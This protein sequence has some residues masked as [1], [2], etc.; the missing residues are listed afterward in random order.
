MCSWKKTC[1]AVV[2]IVDQRRCYIT[3]E[4]LIRRT[5]DAAAA[6]GDRDRAFVDLQFAG[7]PPIRGSRQEGLRDDVS[8]ARKLEP[9]DDRIQPPGRIAQEALSLPTGKSH[10]PVEA[11]A[12]YGNCGIDPIIF[13]RFKSRLGFRKRPCIQPLGQHTGRKQL[14]RIQHAVAESVPPTRKAFEYT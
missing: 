1:Y 12:M 9:A 6:I 14:S 2:R 11:D 8:N 7:R 13:I 5:A 10:N 4:P 3:V